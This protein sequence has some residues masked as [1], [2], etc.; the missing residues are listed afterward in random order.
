MAA[1]GIRYEDLH[2]G[3]LLVGDDGLWRMVDFGGCTLDGDPA[4]TERVHAR[5]MRLLLE[6]SFAH[7]RVGWRWV[8]WLRRVEAG[9]GQAG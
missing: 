7:T 6:A 4:E 2:A 8:N 1:A 9:E 5:E 3:N